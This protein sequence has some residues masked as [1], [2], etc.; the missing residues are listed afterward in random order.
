[1][2][3]FVCGDFLFFL[4]F[5]QHMIPSSF[6]ASLAPCCKSKSSKDLPKNLF[7]EFCSTTTRDEE[8]DFGSSGYTKAVEAKAWGVKNFAQLSDPDIVWHLPSKILRLIG[9]GSQFRKTWCKCLQVCVDISERMPPLTA[10]C[11]ADRTPHLTK[12]V[13]LSAPANLDRRVFNG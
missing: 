1:M 4:V 2:I 5:V 9:P 6:S 10:H 12:L 7:Y 3:F 11:F 8:A 13:L